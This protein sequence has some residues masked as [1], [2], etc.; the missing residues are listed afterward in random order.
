MAKAKDYYWKGKVKWCRPNVPDPWGFYKTVFYPDATSLSEIKSLKEMDAKGVAGLKNVIK[1]DED[2]EFLSLRR[3]VQKTFKGLVQ[4][5]G[6]PQVL[7]GSKQLE[8]G[9][10]MPLRDINI[11]NGSD[12]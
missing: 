3:D 12:A 6:P 5:L 4:A 1:K 2:G 10:Y 7:D 8:D 11:G 9:S